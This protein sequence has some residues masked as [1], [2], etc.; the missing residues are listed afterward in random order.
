MAGFPYVCVPSCWNMIDC[1]LGAQL[2][3]DGG[4][5]GRPSLGSQLRVIRIF[6]SSSQNYSILRVL[7]IMYFR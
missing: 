4:I 6:V 5:W 7:Q 2:L 3:L 1:V